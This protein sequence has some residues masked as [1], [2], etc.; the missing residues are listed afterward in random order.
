MI[1]RRALM[2]GEKKNYVGKWVEKKI[3]NTDG[4][5]TNYSANKISPYFKV[6]PG[7]QIKF[8]VAATD[9]CGIV[10]YTTVDIDLSTSNTAKPW[11][12]YWGQSIRERTITLK[13]NTHFIVFNYSPV[14]GHWQ[15]SKGYIK[16]VTTGEYIWQK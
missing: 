16:D 1:R 4:S 3:I 6:T 14:Y 11:N 12:A 15:V 7:H 10:E 5:I 13:N 9:T 2:N 8:D